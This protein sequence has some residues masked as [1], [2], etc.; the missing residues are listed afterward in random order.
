MLPRFME[1]IEALPKFTKN[2]VNLSGLMKIVTT[3]PK[4]KKSV[5][6]SEESSK[7]N[8]MIPYY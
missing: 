4:F 1:Y 6:P 8:W 5:E 3:L 2:V 7:D